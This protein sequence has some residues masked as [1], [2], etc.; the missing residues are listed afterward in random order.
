MAVEVV[1]TCKD[2]AARVGEGQGCD[3][4]VQGGV[5]I[6][7]DLLVGAQVVHL[8]GTVVGAGDDH[9]PAVEEL[10]GQFGY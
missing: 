2:E 9:I 6:V 1:I 10:G 4:G 3:A 7:H 8:A 5:G